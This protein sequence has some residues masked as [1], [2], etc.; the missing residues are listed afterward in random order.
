MRIVRCALGASSHTRI[1]SG[2]PQ[3]GQEVGAHLRT[4]THENLR[5]RKKLSIEH[6]KIHSTP[7]VILARATEHMQFYAND[8][9]VRSS[10]HQNDDMNYPARSRVQSTMSR[11]TE[12][13][14]A[15]PASRS[16]R[17]HCAGQTLNAHVHTRI[18]S[19]KASLVRSRVTPAK[20]G[21]ARPGP[22][23]KTDNH[24][25]K[26]TA[27]VISL[28][29]ELGQQQRATQ[30]RSRGQASYSQQHRAPVKSN[31]GTIL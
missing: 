2:A 21:D 18:K 1:C 25:R 11:K 12:D 28:D 10:T 9:L 23:N 5:R 17:Y 30:S 13:R 3:G 24:T 8:Y 29:R 27:M 6:R 31:T 7:N 26:N 22:R 4:Y 16:T 19:G 14:Q 15:K 20:K